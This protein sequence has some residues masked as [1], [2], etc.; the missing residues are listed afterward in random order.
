MTFWDKILDKYPMKLQATKQET[1]TI[2]IVLPEWFIA[3]NQEEQ[4]C[5]TRLHNDCVWNVNPDKLWIYFQNNNIVEQETFFELVPYFHQVTN[6]DLYTGSAEYNNKKITWSP[7]H[8]WRYCNNMTVHF[9]KTLTKGTN[10]ELSSDKS[11]SKSNPDKD[12]A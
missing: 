12:T 1:K 9:N 2:P 11:S 6:F 4:V 8:Q 3:N 5:F 10:S 7:I